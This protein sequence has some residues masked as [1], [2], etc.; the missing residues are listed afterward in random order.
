MSH[1]D[2]DDLG[3]DLSVREPGTIYHIEVYKQP[4]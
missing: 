1:D 4:S 3:V 2:E